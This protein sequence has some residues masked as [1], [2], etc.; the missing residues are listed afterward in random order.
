MEVE[1]EIEGVYKPT[2]DKDKIKKEI[3]ESP[4]V[5]N[6]VCLHVI[7][8]QYDTYFVHVLFLNIIER[9]TLSCVYELVNQR[10]KSLSEISLSVISTV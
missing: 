3:A 10:L 5:R 1:I 9:E 2:V 8:D 7:H 4:M 6:I